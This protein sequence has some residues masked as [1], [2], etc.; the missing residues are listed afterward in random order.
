MCFKS[1]LLRYILLCTLFCLFL[2]RCDISNPDYRDKY[3][4]KWL[5]YYTIKD[6]NYISK[7]CNT[8]S[9][10]GFGSV[11]Y[12]PQHSRNTVTIR[13]SVKREEVLELDHSGYFLNCEASGSFSDAKYVYLVW[14][15]RAN[16][17]GNE[18]MT[19][20]TL[21]GMKL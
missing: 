8:F 2:T 10:N 11:F 13:F 21:A 9:G 6:C 4:G 15:Q 18:A 5:F 12:T 14:T 17:S 1:C 3:S 19:S 20:F 16:C 7:V